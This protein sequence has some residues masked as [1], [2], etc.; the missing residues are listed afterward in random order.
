MSLSAASAGTTSSSNSPRLFGIPYGDFGLFASLLLSLALG[1]MT[2][3][4]V[5]FLSIFGIL[6]Y[7]AVT[8]GAIDL[9][10]GYKY[11]AFP[12]GLLVL[13]LSLLTLGTVWMRRRV[14]G[15]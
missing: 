3:F 4:G 7:N 1:F 8:H 5:T 6:I 9:S 12:A 15:K 11:I 2:F 13:V 10:H 14:L